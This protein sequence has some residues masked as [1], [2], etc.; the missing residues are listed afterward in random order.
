MNSDWGAA[1]SLADEL[2]LTVLAVVG[3]ENTRA[4]LPRVITSDRLVVAEDLSEGISL[5]ETE[6]PDIA[7]VD[8]G[9]NDGAGLAMVHHLK[10]LVPDSTI[11]A[12][13]D[14]DEL[15][16]GAHALALGGAGLFLMPLG[17]DEVL[18]ALSS[19]RTR[20][21]ERG[22]RARLERDSAVTSRA[23]TWIARLAALS[24]ARD[25]S[26]AAQ[27]VAEIFSE[28][29]GAA[30]V[31]VYLVVG[32]RTTELMRSAAIGA[33]ERAPSFGT[34]V[35]L[36]DYA[37]R[38]RLAV[39]PL[40]LRKV[41]AGH[42]VLQTAAAP[43]VL[44]DGAPGGRGQ[45]AWSGAH[46]GIHPHG[47]DGPAS[48]PES[49]EQSA[50]PS[51]SMPALAGDP[52][53][54]PSRRA[55]LLGGLLKLLAMQS[56]TALALLGERDR[57]SGG[58][59]MKDPTSSAYS[60][61]YYVDVAGREIDKARRYGRRFSI[62]TILIEPSVTDAPVRIPMPPPAELQLPL[63][64]DVDAAWSGP[65][66]VRTSWTE[67]SIPPSGAPTGKP[68]PFAMDPAELADVLL[69]AA[70][71]TDILARVDENEFH[72]LMPETAGLDAHACYR[73]VVARLAA[74]DKQEGRL[75]RGLL[76]G[77]TTFPHDGQN[78][79]QLLRIARRRAE[80]TKD[81]IV[82]RLPREARTLAEI[83]DALIATVSAAGNRT[84]PP[85]SVPEAARGGGSVPPRAFPISA[86]R[87][88]ELALPEAVALATS[89]VRS[90]LR[91][92][93][94]FIVVAHHPGLSLGAAVRGALGTPREDVILHALDIRSI[95][96]CDDVEALCI[97]AEHGAY[98]FLGR[99]RD[100]LMRGVHAADPLLADFM[101]ERIG[102]AAGLRVFG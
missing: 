78:L 81:S 39:V 65:P 22:L 96:G 48:A 52:L 54:P 87:L 70:R 57:A 63:S 69:D 86:P 27:Q 28:S 90:A 42:V 88:L 40:A 92:G 41:A 6:V 64:A 75:P 12:L 85:P 51:S 8:V 10:A 77:V 82:H 26:A 91:G 14:Q 68:S 32:D 59:A 80:A 1:A 83:T 37:R 13:A 31:A 79:A 67:P 2:R 50:R 19:V 23:A 33:L 71:D 61:A 55:P 93:A 18:N 3:D 97:L 72:L 99:S 7:F 11:F 44:D 43:L 35:D 24:D 73:R 84:D 30:G 62:A 25:R 5:A 60:F 29:T 58:A 38:E 15:E 36:L 21:A 9:L 98:A 94:A 66:G 16:A 34:E 46:E 95:P 102:R 4:F 45:P 53:A 74:S 56:T 49:S 17:G 89:A 100:G 101:A 47:D 76:M 20:L